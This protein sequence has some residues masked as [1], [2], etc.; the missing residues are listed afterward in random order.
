MKPLGYY[1]IH[2]HE[3]M[4][5]AFAR[6]LADETLTRRHWQVLNTIA[7]GPHTQ[8]EINAALKPFGDDF[9]EQVNDLTARGW[10]SGEHH[11]TEAGR[12]AHHRVS[13]RVDAFRAKVV[14]GISVD[15]YR[16]LVR[17][18]DRVATNTDA[19]M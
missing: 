11:L 8:A 3:T 15:E 19:L 18:L 2:I 4:E 1:L 12:E 7:T 16:T 6:L 5:N 14:N 13:E 17:L 9:R 10:I